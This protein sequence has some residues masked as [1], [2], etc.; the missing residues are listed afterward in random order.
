VLSR[1]NQKWFADYIASIDRF[2]GK[3]SIY[4]EHKLDR[5]TKIFAGFFNRFTL[6]IRSRKFLDIANVS[7]REPFEKP[8]LMKCS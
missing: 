1:A 8:P 7:P 5:F 2:F 6:G 4:L 3:L